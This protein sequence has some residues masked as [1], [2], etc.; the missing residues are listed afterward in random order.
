ME[1]SGG[2][3]AER[4]FHTVWRH[5]VYNNVLIIDFKLNRLGKIKVASIY[6]FQ[7]KLF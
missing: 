4:K 6:F 5:C 1:S 3:A 2:S 7:T